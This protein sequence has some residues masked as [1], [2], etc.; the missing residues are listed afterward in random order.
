MSMEKF[1][2]NPEETD[3]IQT[4]LLYYR[5]EGLDDDKYELAVKICAYMKSKERVNICEGKKLAD[6]AKER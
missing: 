3:L 6:V 1:W 5:A 2:F 4:A